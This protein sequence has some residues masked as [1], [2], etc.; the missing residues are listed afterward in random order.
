[1]KKEH[2]EKVLLL[3][4]KF[5]D[6]MNIIIMIIML[7]IIIGAVGFLIRDIFAFYQAGF[8]SSIGTMLGSLLVLWVLLELL[9]T[10]ID[11]LKG[12]TFNIS[13]FVLVAMVA[14]IRKL[15]VA[16]LKPEKLEAAYYPLAVIGVLG[17]VYW[18]IKRAEKT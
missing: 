11:Y 1:M 14:F 18:L 16:S 6:L 2:K 12:G 8:A 4:E 7:V 17:I 10:Q 5:S 13:V 3:S 15:M 9:H